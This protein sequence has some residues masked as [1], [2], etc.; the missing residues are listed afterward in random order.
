MNMKS[1]SLVYGIPAND[2]CSD[3]LKNLGSLQQE[4]SDSGRKKARS[5]IVTSLQ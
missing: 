3:E 2:T 5:L 1:S 4:K